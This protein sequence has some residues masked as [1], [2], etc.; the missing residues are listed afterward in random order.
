M[1]LKQM[2]YHFTL[3]EKLSYFPVLLLMILV[4]N[5]HPLFA[6]NTL[7]LSDFSFFQAPGPSWE[8]CW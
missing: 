7:P 6:Q 4:V 1:V 3:T 2:N 5:F 8:T